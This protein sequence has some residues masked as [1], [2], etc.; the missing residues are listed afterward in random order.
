MLLKQQ[1]EAFARASQSNDK[2][3]L[4]KYLDPD[5][6]FTNETGET[7]SRQDLLADPSPPSGPPP[8]NEIV[9]WTLRPQGDVAT[10]TF[11]DVVTR[12]VF[13][14]VVQSRFRSTEVWA[15]RADGWKMIASD[16]AYVPHDP[17]SIKLGAADLDT[18]VGVYQL[19]PG[20]KVSITRVGEGLVSSTN[21]APA[22]P[23]AF[24][25][26]DVAFVPGDIGRRLFLRGP[27]GRVEGY[28]SSRNGTDLGFRR[29]G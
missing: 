1:T 16:S 28:I 13:G 8:Q 18:Y 20:L 24:E 3:M 2:A 27:S 12:D 7:A 17:P 21:G 5:V 15:L 9:N 23:L 25:V 22:T 4:A 10:A 11:T 26:R 29:V 19:A 6:V 14:H